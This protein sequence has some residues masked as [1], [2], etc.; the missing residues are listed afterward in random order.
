VTEN[1][2]YEGVVR[3]H[4][5]VK[6]ADGT[7]LY[8]VNSTGK[9]SRLSIIG[10]KAENYMEGYSDALIQVAKSLVEDA[11]FRKALKGE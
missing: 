10:F 3:L 7:Q 4:L 6:K 5:L 9:S 11:G 2:N 1:R 8:E